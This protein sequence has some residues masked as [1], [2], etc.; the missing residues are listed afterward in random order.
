MLNVV[1]LK[2][3]YFDT[4]F[5]KKLNNHTNL[6]EC[7]YLLKDLFKYDIAIVP[8]F[9]DET[10]DN[11]CLIVVIKIAKN[12]V[13]LYDRERTSDSNIVYYII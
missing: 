11:R 13:D 5:S 6:K 12:S 3:L 4:N 1:P 2:I 10:N 9:F 8:F 7:C